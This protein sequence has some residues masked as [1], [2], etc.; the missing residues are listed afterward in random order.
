[1]NDNINVMYNRY[2]C[3][4]P[5]LDYESTEKYWKFIKDSIVDVFGRDRIN[6]W[7]SIYRDEHGETFFITYVSVYNS[8]ESIVK[9]LQCLVGKDFVVLE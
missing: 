5:T 7:A 3:G 6:A 1:M 2:R 9:L 4:K 8:N